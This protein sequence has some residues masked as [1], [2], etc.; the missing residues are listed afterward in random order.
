MEGKALTTE[1]LLINVGGIV[2]IKSDHFAMIKVIQ[3]TV[4]NG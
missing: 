3:P 4:I 1:R 2:K